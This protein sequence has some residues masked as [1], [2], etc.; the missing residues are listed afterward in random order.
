M[1]EHSCPSPANS[2]PFFITLTPKHSKAVKYITNAP[3]EL[4]SSLIF[5]MVSQKYFPGIEIF[6]SPIENLFDHPWRISGSSS[7]IFHRHSEDRATT[8]DAPWRKKQRRITR[9]TELYVSADV[10]R[11]MERRVV[12]RNFAATFHEASFL[13]VVE[14][15]ATRG[16]SNL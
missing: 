1:F 6:C 4:D 15:A 5:C 8:R 3:E 11:E 9:S 2:A 10:T 13:I 14:R 16:H 7:R 12:P